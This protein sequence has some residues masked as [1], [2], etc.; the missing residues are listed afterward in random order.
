MKLLFNSWVTL[1]LEKSS[2]DISLVAVDAM[3]CAHVCVD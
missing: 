3:L 2:L 1:H